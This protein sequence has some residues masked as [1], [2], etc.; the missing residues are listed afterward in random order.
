MLISLFENWYI[1]LNNHIKSK[2]IEMAIKGEIVVDIER[3]KGCGVCIP[4][5]PNAVIALSKNVNKKGY[6]YLEA[7]K[8]TVRTVLL[9]VLM[10]QSLFTKLKYKRI[11]K[12]NKWQKS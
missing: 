6:N 11:K 4:V 7:V 2:N 8:D 12:T 5:C 3:C 10:V 1:N 9:F